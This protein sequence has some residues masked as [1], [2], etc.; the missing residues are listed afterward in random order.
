MADEIITRWLPIS[1][2]NQCRYTEDRKLKGRLTWDTCCIHPEVGCR[3]KI[4]VAMDRFPD[5][6]PLPVSLD[7]KGAAK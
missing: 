1:N 3:V 6:C 2:C 7:L 5:W 4:L